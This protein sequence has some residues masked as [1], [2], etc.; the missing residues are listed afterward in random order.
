MELKLN[1]YEKKKIVKTYTTDTYDLM[2]G[3]V[4][5]FLDITKVD[6]VKTGSDVELAMIVVKALPKGRETINNLFKDVFDGL[7]DE[8]LKYTKVKD[9]TNIL[10]NIVKSSVLEINKGVNEKN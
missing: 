6:Q 5:D 7:T 1:I 8:E 9:I 2:Y 10:I 4:E 3:I